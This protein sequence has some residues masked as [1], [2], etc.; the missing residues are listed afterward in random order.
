MS[1]AIRSSRLG[2]IDPMLTGYFQDTTNGFQ[3]FV[4]SK[5]APYCDVDALGGVATIT[6]GSSEINLNQ[7]PDFLSPLADNAAA[8]QVATED[9]TISIKLERYG[10]SEFVNYARVRAAERAGVDYDARAMTLLA[11]RIQRSHEVLL[12]QGISNS[13]NYDAANIHST[14]NFQTSPSASLITPLQNFIDT[15]GSNIHY[16]PNTI[17]MTPKVALY[18]SLIDEIA[19]WNGSSS[20][21]STAIPNRKKLYEFFKEQ[22]D[23]DLIIAREHYTD[24]SGTRGLAMGKSIALLRTDV[25]AKPN[26]CTTWV[27]DWLGTFTEAGTSAEGVEGGSLGL[28]GVTSIEM[29]DPRGVK[30]L[31]ETMFQLGFHNSAAGALFTGVIT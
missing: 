5:I 23:L 15:I 17:V 29:Q 24:V 2:V 4:G 10:F 30:Y 14:T 25:A 27:N 12:L 8:R 7:N 28:A 19:A 31:A 11:E 6:K 20:H 1:I 18:L 26:F 3:S 16:Q 22:F 9:D 21:N 13:S